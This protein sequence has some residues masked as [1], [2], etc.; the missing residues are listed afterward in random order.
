MEFSDHTN[1]KKNYSER[2][3]KF[4]AILKKVNREIRL[5]SFS[6]LALAVLFFVLMYVGFTYFLFFY[7]LPIPSILFFILLKKHAI[8]NDQKIEY[9]NLAELNRLEQCT[10]DY[11][12]SNFSN[13]E[14]FID[15]QHSFSH[16]LDVFGKGSLFQYLNRCATHLGEKALANSLVSSQLNL[17]QI[18]GRQQAISELSLHID[19]RQE[20]WAKGKSV[21]EKINDSDSILSWLNEKPIISNRIF[22]CLEK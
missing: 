5:V 2:E 22:T 9:Q 18:E 8:L 12:F 15:Q 20:I 6:R 10:L 19:F 4:N 14:Q 7:L 3:K 13:G 16:D 1:L 17:I 21:N 11:H